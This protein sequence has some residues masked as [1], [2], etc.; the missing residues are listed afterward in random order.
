MLILFVKKTCGYTR[1]HVFVDCYRWGVSDNAVSPAFT[2]LDY[3]LTVYDET[4]PVT[5]LYTVSVTES[6]EV[7]MTTATTFF[8][9]DSN[10]SNHFQREQ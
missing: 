2:N 5:S 3:T 6:P 8:T 10:S 4:P 7:T 1:I 9:F